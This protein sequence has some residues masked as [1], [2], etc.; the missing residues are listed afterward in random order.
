MP[1]AITF[2]DFD[3]TDAPELAEFSEAGERIKAL[4]DRLFTEFQLDGWKLVFD[5]S[6]RRLGE[7]RYTQK[8]IGISVYYLHN[9]EETEDTLRHEVAHAITPGHGHDDTWR[10]ACYKT[11]AKP[12]RL[13]DPHVKSAATANYTIECQKCGTQFARYRLRPALLK[14]YHC[15][16]IING[17][18]CKGEFIA[19]DK[20]GYIYGKGGEN[21]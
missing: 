2:G 18:P 1:K 3:P 21:R 4:A 20:D 14:R 10:M 6:R 13:A 17:E 9:I 5:K 15:A 8:E 19:M 7:C 16:R 12:A 11:G